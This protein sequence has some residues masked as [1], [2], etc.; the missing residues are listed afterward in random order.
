MHSIYIDF[1]SLV[2]SIV[3]SNNKDHKFSKLNTIDDINKSALIICNVEREILKTLNIGDDYYDPQNGSVSLRMLNKELHLLIYKYYYESKATKQQI[4]EIIDLFYPITRANRYLALSSLITYIKLELEENEIDLIDLR[5][6]LK[7]NALFI[8]SLKNYYPRVKLLK[9]LNKMKSLI[10]DKALQDTEKK[11]NLKFVENFITPIIKLA[12]Y[13]N[14][15]MLI[16]Q[17]RDN[18]YRYT[19]EELLNCLFG[20]FQWKYINFDLFKKYYTQEDLYG[21]DEFMTTEDIL[22]YSYKLTKSASITVIL[23]QTLCCSIPGI[24]YLFNILLDV[25]NKISQPFDIP[26]IDAKHSSF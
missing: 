23:Y 21:K 16:K 1:D 7:H 6:Y 20:D 14:L 9:L 3:S 11:M 10:D 25:D 12:F 24:I 13:R 15:K 22:K 8:A 2:E 4:L 18:Y 26:D 17:V 5:K 19:R